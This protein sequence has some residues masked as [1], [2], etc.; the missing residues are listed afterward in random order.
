V[1]NELGYIYYSDERGGIKKYR[2]DPE[3][4]DADVELAVF[5]TDGFRE[6]REG[7]SIYKIDDGTGY[8]LVSDQQANAFRIFPREGEPDNPH[9]HREIKVVQASTNESDGSDVTSR[10]LGE[11]FP[12]GLF[13]AM[14][15]DGTF[16]L[17][18]W[19][20]IAGDDLVKAPNGVA[21]GG[22]GGSW[23]R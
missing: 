7:I 2:A 22:Q 18:S 14:S 21:S 15:D 11:S 20:D 23:S 1:D 9:E 10:V 8:I 3:A 19:D 5:G 6:D 17:Y 16:Q 13:V 4:P 12:S